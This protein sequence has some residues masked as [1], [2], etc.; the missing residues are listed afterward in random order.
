MK[1]RIFIFITIFVVMF[2][3]LCFFF[4]QIKNSTESC[5][6]LVIK[7]T[8]NYVDTYDEI[9]Q[10]DI[11]LYVSNKNSFITEKKSVGN[12]YIK[13]NQEKLEV[14]LLD[15]IDRKESVKINN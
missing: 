9:G 7:K 12:C 2:F 4:I 3:V 5:K 8:Y 13:S 15:I 14:K 1:K 11:D 10:I 6:V